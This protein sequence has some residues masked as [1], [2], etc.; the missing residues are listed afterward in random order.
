MAPRVRGNATAAIRVEHLAEFRSQ[1]KALGNS[2]LDEEF[3]DANQRIADIVVQRARSRAGSLGG[4]EAKVAKSLRATRSGFRA[5][6]SYGGARYPQAMG[7]EFGAYRDKLRLRKATGGRAYIVRKE[8]KREIAKAI[9]RIEAQRNIN[10]GEQSK[11]TGRVRG[12]NQFPKWTGNGPTAGRF[13]FPALRAAGDEI[14]R[15]YAAAIDEITKK[16]FPE[17]G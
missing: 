10:T 1:L 7:Y 8:S 14:E 5:E 12:W 3:K 13:L 2:D 17:G 4:A 9:K 16:A 11:V 6:V 15:E